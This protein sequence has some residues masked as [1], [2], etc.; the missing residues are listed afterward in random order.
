M[1]VESDALGLTTDGRFGA[2]RIDLERSRPGVRRHL[3]RLVAQGTIPVVTGY[4]GEDSRGRVT[5]LGPG[6]SDYSATAL[7][8]LLGAKRVDLVKSRYA[9]LTA[10]PAVVPHARP[11][12]HLS[13]SEAE[14]LSQ[15][16][17]SVLHPAAIEP[18]RRARVPIQV[19]TLGD[20][21]RVTVIDQSPGGAAARSVSWLGP[22]LYAR[23]GVPGGRAR[24]GVVRRLFEELETRGTTL[25]GISSTPSEVRLLLDLA[26][27]TT[28]SRAGL[29]RATVGLGAEITPPV[30]VSVVTLLGRNAYRSL[31]RLPPEI[32]RASLAVDVSPRSVSFVLPSSWTARGCRLL[33]RLFV[34][35]GAPP[36]QRN[37]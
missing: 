10:D 4:F 30:R 13:Y 23:A 3:I 16:G 9:I 32:L 7:S 29:A 21:S 22:F 31:A 11:I 34:E 5:T 33:H 36:G 8:A 25:S 15:F 28:P 17:A 19:R 2:A 14:E 35:P 37:A 6:G 20:P 27:G 18:A 12:R 24:P 1:A 26:A